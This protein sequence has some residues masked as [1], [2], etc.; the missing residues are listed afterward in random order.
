MVSTTSK[1]KGSE[2]IKRKSTLLHTP[3]VDKSVSKI[4]RS[5]KNEQH[6]KT[7]KH[8]TKSTVSPKTPEP[9]NKMITSNKVNKVLTH[10]KKKSVCKMNNASSIVQ[11]VDQSSRRVSKPVGP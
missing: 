2:S 1:G 8:V 10:S 11:I 3:K 4:Q 6:S 9:V 5:S 7:P